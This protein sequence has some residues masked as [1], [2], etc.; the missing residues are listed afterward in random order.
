MFFF[1]EFNIY[2]Y[3]FCMCAVNC[4]SYTLFLGSIKIY[5]F[6]LHSANCSH[7]VY[8][9]S[10]CCHTCILVQLWMQSSAVTHSNST[11]AFL[12]LHKQSRFGN[13]LSNTRMHIFVC[14]CC[15]AQISLYVSICMHIISIYTACVCVCDCVSLK[16]FCYVWGDLVLIGSFAFVSV[17]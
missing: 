17:V 11:D 8:V 15:T 9:S 1:I 4:N 6:K 10:S 12:C 14:L 3:F 5:N 13:W 16:I 7:S 2:I